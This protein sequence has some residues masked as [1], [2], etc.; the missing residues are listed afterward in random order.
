[1]DDHLWNDWFDQQ[2]DFDIPE[3]KFVDADLKGIGRMKVHRERDCQG[4]NC[5][6]HNPSDHHMKDWD[7]RWST[8]KRRM[9]RVCPLHG[10]GHPDPDDTV[11]RAREFGDTDTTHDCCGCCNEDFLILLDELLHGETSA[12]TSEEEDVD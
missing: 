7:Y 5:S 4:R 12:I 2:W 1:M 10:K 11:F 3:P 9:S 8:E 6:I